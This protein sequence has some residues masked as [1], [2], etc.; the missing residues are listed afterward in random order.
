LELAKKFDLLSMKGGGYYYLPGQDKPFA[1]GE[2]AAIEFLASD[3][4]F[5]YDLQ[6]RVV[7][8]VKIGIV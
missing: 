7:K 4:D 3:L 8:E 1:Q 5:Y 6:S 2:A